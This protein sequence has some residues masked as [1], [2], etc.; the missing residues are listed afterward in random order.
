MNYETLI[1]V[2]I[3]SGVISSLVAV[4]ANRKNNDADTFLKL[5]ATV[6]SLTD[7]LNEE[8]AARRSDKSEFE[9]AIAALQTKYDTIV[10]GLERRISEL[11]RERNELLIENRRL[12]EAGK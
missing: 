4:Y 2:L 10:Q 9:N 12:R 3:T 7:D 1:T 6:A 5:S 11:E 8:R